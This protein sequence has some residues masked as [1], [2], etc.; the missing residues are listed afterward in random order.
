MSTLA[1]ILQRPYRATV[2]LLLAVTMLIVAI[3]LVQ[4]TYTIVHVGHVH[5][6]TFFGEAEP[7]PYNPGFHLV[8]PLLNFTAFDTRKRTHMET[9]QVPSQDQ[10]TT[11]FDVSAQY[12]IIAAQAPQTLQ[13]TGTAAQA[14]QVHLVPTFRSVFRETGRRVPRAEDFFLETTQQTMQSITLEQMRETLGPKGIEIDQILIRDVRLPQFITDAIEQKKTADQEA[15]RAVAEVERHRTQQQQQV[16]KATADKQAAILQA[17]ARRDAASL[18]AEQ[19]TILAD[20][21]AY[22]IRAV[23]EAVADNPTYLRLRQIDALE[24]I[25]EDPAAKLYF[26]NPEQGV[27]PLMHV[28]GA[29]TRIVGGDVVDRPDMR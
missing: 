3:V 4:R 13:E 27:L 22:E 11:Q 16:N 5:V 10:L 1:N 15:A 14:V 20:A 8:N 7:E 25:A 12:R 19:R 28:G 9:I 18:E 21:R 26:I 2:L 23:N 24:K 17:E 6:A 29:D